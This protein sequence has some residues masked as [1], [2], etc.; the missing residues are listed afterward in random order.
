MKKILMPEVSY[1]GQNLKGEKIEKTERRIKDLKDIFTDKE[2]LYQLPPDQ[3]VYEVESYLPVQEGTTGGLFF[4]VTYIHPGTVG[5]EYFM[6]KGHFHKIMDRGEFYWCTEGEG[7]LLLMDTDRKTWAENM[8]PGSLH[9][10]NGYTAHRTAN[11]GSNI[12]VFGAC[13]PADA[14]HDYTTISTRGF[15]KIL[16]KQNGSPA[17]IDHLEKQDSEKIKNS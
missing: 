16:V 5:N 14:G 13:W 15:A 7:M 8:Y 6:T 2:A 9:Y 12:L 17:L 1:N 3:I 4:G 11:T 10:I